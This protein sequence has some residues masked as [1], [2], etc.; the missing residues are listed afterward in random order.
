M[1]AFVHLHTHSWYSEDG[2]SSVQ[3]LVSRAVELG[4]PALAIT[5]HNSIA[6]VEELYKFC[7]LEGI[8]PIIGVELQVLPFVLRDI[9]N[10]S[11][12]LLA[13][14]E[15]GYRN[16]CR[17][18]SVEQVTREELAEFSQGLIAL[19]GGTKNELF[20]AVASGDKDDVESYLNGI[21]S[22]F[23]LRNVYIELQPT[24]DVL[25]QRNNLRLLRLAEYL[26]IPVVATNNVHYIY[27]E[28]DICHRFLLRES[29][30]ISRAAEDYLKECVNNTTRHLASGEEMSGYFSNVPEALQNSLK[31]AE[32]CQ[33]LLSELSGK[34]RLY[35]YERGRDPESFLWDLVSQQAK[36]HYG[37]LSSEVKERVNEEFN[38]ILQEGLSEFL[39]FLYYLRRW[40]KENNLYV[41]IRTGSILS[42]VIAYVLGIIDIDPIK[43]Q[44][45]FSGL[46]QKKDQFAEVTLDISTQDYLPLLHYLQ[47]TYGSEHIAGTGKFS[48]WHKGALLLELCQWARLTPVSLTRSLSEGDVKSKTDRTL[49]DCLKRSVDASMRICDVEFLKLMVNTLGKRPRRFEPE[50]GGVAIA[51]QRIN[52]LVP[53]E[54][55][56][57]EFLPLATVTKGWLD[58]LRLIRIQFSH[59]TVMNIIRDTMSM[60][61]EQ[62]NVVRIPDNCYEDDG[63]YRFL[64][65]GKT[66]GIPFFDGVTARS[67]LRRQ[68]PKDI[69]QLVRTRALLREQKYTPRK[70]SNTHQEEEKTTSI[71]SIVADCYLACVCAYLMTKFSDYY[72]GAVIKNYSRWRHRLQLLLRGLRY[73]GINILPPDVNLSEFDFVREEKGLRAGLR[74]IK[75]IGEKVYAEIERV[76]RGGAFNDLVDLCR[77]TDSRLVN[78]RIVA[79]LIKSGALDSLGKK[80]SEMLALLDKAVSLARQRNEQNTQKMSPDF[81]DITLEEVSEQREMDFSFQMELSELPLR[82]IL[83]YE[84]QATGIIFSG[85][86]FEPYEELLDKMNVRPLW[87]LTPKL[88]N[89]EVHFAGL[90]DD[91][92][93][94]SGVLC[95]PDIAAVIGVNG[96]LVVIPRRIY[97]RSR[98]ALMSDEPVLIGGKV[99]KE[100][101]EL[102]VRASYLYSLKEVEFKALNTL[103]VEIDMLGENQN[104]LKLIYQIMKLY[105]GA[106]RVRVRNFDVKRRARL[107][108]RI[109]ERGIIFCPPVYFKL[110]KLLPERAIRPIIKKEKSPPTLLERK[111]GERTLPIF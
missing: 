63:V 77:R 28:E 20:H 104:T 32:R 7:A 72:L 13:E 36:E 92:E 42:S 33:L 50:R 48:Y 109:D 84:K 22:I 73:E 95:K 1:T 93:R 55:R 85:Y 15:T 103:E 4:M 100:D 102:F 45:R 65:T 81:F 14:Q 105:P 58:K 68:Q 78:H 88:L 37:T 3:G 79:N 67:L 56:A 86:G 51:S 96:F 10:P 41:T 110:V 35:S 40:T 23:G 39:I 87:R 38:Y 52:S 43:F 61:T 106:T 30:D 29:V 24:Q 19:I 89:K 27:P 46:K 69:F 16:L 21:V 53:V 76:R 9:E 8:K 71:Y 66:T 6:G 47:V 34:P 49:S 91:V 75:G 60:I 62:E 111:K 31:I 11:I 70:E 101:G 97:G 83:E 18:L 108:R 80:R 12:I 64:S 59:S 98:R 17:L 107:L 2:V 54:N 94:N 82:Q 90:V 25:H 99:L 74:I 57:G 26:N 5:D 44:F